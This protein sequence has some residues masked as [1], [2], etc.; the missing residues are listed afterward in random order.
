[1]AH[2]RDSDDGELYTRR[3]VDSGSKRASG[4]SIEIFERLKEND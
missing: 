2:L 1:M 3:V 4:Q